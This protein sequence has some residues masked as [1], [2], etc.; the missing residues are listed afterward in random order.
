MEPFLAAKAAEPD[1]G[2]RAVLQ[3]LHVA[4]FHALPARK[5]FRTWREE[6]WLGASVFLRGVDI[7]KNGLNAYGRILEAE[8]A[9]L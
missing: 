6:T 4:A 2:R 9:L 8:A 1:D 7:P 5:A 3:L